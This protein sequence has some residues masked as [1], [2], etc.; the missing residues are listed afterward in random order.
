MMNATGNKPLLRV[1]TPSEARRRRVRAVDEETLAEA[2][3]IL[4]AI[5]AGGDEAALTYARRFGDLAKGQS[6]LLTRAELEA[7]RDVLPVEQRE[8][9]ERTAERIRGFALAQR[10]AL[11]D[12]SVAIAGGSGRAGHRFVPVSA[13]GCYAPG[14]RYPLPSSVLMTVVTARAAGVAS[15]WA[16]SPRPTAVT[17]AAAAIAGADGL[18][19]IGGVQAIAALARG[20]LGVPAC[21]M[22]AGP[23]N[24]WVTAAKQL[25]SGEVGIDMLAGPSELVVLADETADAG[26]IA[27]DLLAQAEHDDDAAAMLVCTS[28]ALAADVEAEL[29]A[30]LAGLATRATAERALANGFAVVAAS[31]D[32]AIGLCD[33]IAPEHL[34]IMTR[35]SEGT[36]K[37]ITN[38]GAIFVGA[39]SAEVLGDYGAGPNHVLPTGG[40]ARFR[41]GLSVL[42]FL[43]ARTWLAIDDAK[44]DG[45]RGLAEDA[46]A[47]ARLESL[48][49]HARSAERRMVRAAGS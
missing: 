49:G 15:V 8:L 29:L 28:K 13:A 3:V 32:E 22:I 11:A 30:Q 4:A 5:E 34:E 25:V 40:T 46:A 24:R 37:R 41:A 21:D 38:A 6:P 20:L 45:A 10:A 12:V 44:S 18:L 9:L 27:A 33:S 36:A 39:R 35:D 16:A 1:V 17:M 48:E 23:G 47:L 19:A 31:E 43:R 42:T 7:A 2:R 26:I 14:G